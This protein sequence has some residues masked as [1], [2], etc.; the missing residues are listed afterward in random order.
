MFCCMHVRIRTLS[1]MNEWGDL[2]TMMAYFCEQK[3]TTMSPSW[4]HFANGSMGVF[5]KVGATISCFC[6]GCKC[7]Q[8]LADF[9]C[10]TL[11]FEWKVLISI[12]YCDDGMTPWWW[13]EEELPGEILV[14]A[15]LKSCITLRCT[16]FFSLT[17]T[18]CSME[19]EM[20]SIHK[21][22]EIS[23]WQ[24]GTHNFLSKQTWLQTPVPPSC[25]PYWQ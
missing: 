6:Q 7:H 1:L 9:D 8:Q 23:S 5:D 3:A 4:P 24:L 22:I 12:N 18:G 21:N 16:F 13:K 19:G 14:T 15:C 11:F 20:Y 17:E 10:M 2:Q 25:Q